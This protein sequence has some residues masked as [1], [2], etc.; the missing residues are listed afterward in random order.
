MWCYM[1]S[2]LGLGYQSGWH[3]GSA[4]HKCCKCVRGI[5]P[6]DPV[7]L[8]CLA[9]PLLLAVLQDTQPC[10][11]AGLQFKATTSQQYKVLIVVR[12]L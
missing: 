11:T 7:R 9:Q 2:L 12:A 3:S 4:S 8:L 6:Q 10:L 1:V 5:L